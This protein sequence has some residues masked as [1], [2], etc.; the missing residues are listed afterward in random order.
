[1]LLSRARFTRI[2]VEFR[3]FGL[4]LG[5]LR[6]RGGGGEEGVLINRSWKEAE[7]NAGGEEGPH[8]FWAEADASKAETLTP[9]CPKEQGE[10]VKVVLNFF[11]VLYYRLP[12][13]CRRD[14]HPPSISFTEKESKTKLVSDDN[15]C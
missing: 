13:L 6:G 1:M 14:L 5:P 8:I 11:R 2:F 9:F 4:D 12:F 10:H 15:L 3:R 7:E